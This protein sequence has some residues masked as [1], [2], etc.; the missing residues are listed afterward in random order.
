M[1][2]P[3]QG[4]KLLYLLILLNLM[5]IGY[6]YFIMP[7]KAVVTQA[8]KTIKPEEIAQPKPFDVFPNNTIQLGKQ[9]SFKVL[10]YDTNSDS[11]QEKQVSTLTKELTNTIF[12]IDKKTNY[13]IQVD[14]GLG[15]VVGVFYNLYM[16]NENNLPQV[17]LQRLKSAGYVVDTVT[18]NEHKKVVGFKGVNPSNGYSVVVKSSVLGFSVNFI[19]EK[20]KTELSNITADA[21]RKATQPEIQKLPT[22]IITRD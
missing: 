18:M 8:I 1:R 15:Y 10:S 9:D 16:S 11:I 14:Y 19:D 6:L 13:K 4:K 2:K 3:K 5:S 7:D 22:T 17:L 20:K 21:I 12:Y